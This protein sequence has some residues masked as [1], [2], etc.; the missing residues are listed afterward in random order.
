MNKSIFS[1]LP[2]KN[3]SNPS[4]LDWV[5]FLVWMS[6]FILCLKQHV[7]WRDEWQ[8][9]LVSIHT[10]TVSEFFNAIRYERQPPL[11]YVLLRILYEITGSSEKWV[12]QSLTAVFSVAS[13]AMILFGFQLK[14]PLKYLIIFGILFFFEYGVVSRCYALGVFFFTGV[15]EVQA[16][17]GMEFGST[18]FDSAL[19][20]SSLFYRN[21]CSILFALGL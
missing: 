2:K 3:E 1:V 12:F 10:R 20:G 6:F 15:S 4:R 5:V 19:L 18:G 17:A 14:R 7:P 21:C 16:D 9:W 13:A 8:S 11:L